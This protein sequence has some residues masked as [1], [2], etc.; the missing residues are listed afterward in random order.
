MD[1]INAILM[2]ILIIITGWYAFSTHK[3]LNAMKHQSLI[4]INTAKII[5]NTA[6][7][8]AAGHPAGEQPLP[9]IRNLL[10]ELNNMSDIYAKKY[11]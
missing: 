8:N 9:N 6:L 1:C 10:K 7:M 5:A 11:K 4:L 3:T 2:A